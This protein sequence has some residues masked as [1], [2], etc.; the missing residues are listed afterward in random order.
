M[1]NLEGTHPA[2]PKALYKTHKVDAEG[3]MLDPIPVRNL[4]V[5]IGTPVHP[6]S[7][8]CQVGIEHL[9]SKKELPHRNKSTHEALERIVE[10]NENETPINE[11]ANCVSRY[12]KD[13]PQC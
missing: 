9:T 7:K 8:L 3:K 4:T 10:I 2:I 1:T 11:E 12:S 5:G 13:V 6:I